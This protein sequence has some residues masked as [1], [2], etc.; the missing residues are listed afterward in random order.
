M[1]FSFHIYTEHY[2]FKIPNPSTVMHSTRPIYAKQITNKHQNQFPPPRPLIFLNR[3][4]QPFPFPPRPSSAIFPLTSL[5]STLKPPLFIKS[6]PEETCL[7][8][9]IIIGGVAGFSSPYDFALKFS[10]G[11]ECSRNRDPESAMSVL[12]LLLL[13]SER[14][15]SRLGKC[16]WRGVGGLASNGFGRPKETSSE[17]SRFWWRGW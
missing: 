2:L 3:V 13:I 5:L 17:G 15:E 6:V 7:F 14:G 4:P 12:A 11:R 1:T 9:P 10:L 16:L 8:C